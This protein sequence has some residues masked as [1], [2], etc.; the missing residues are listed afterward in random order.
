MEDKIKRYIYYLENDYAFVKEGLIGVNDYFTSNSEKFVKAFLSEYSESNK[1]NLFGNIFFKGRNSLNESNREL[2]KHFLQI[3]F[4]S[5]FYYILANQSTYDKLLNSESTE[6]QILS[7]LSSFIK[8]HIVD[9]SLLSLTFDNE[10][11]DKTLIDTFYQ[12]IDD[13]SDFKIDLYKKVSSLKTSINKEKIH[14]ITK[15]IKLFIKVK[16]DVLDSLIL[17][18]IKFSYLKRYVLNNNEIFCTIADD[19]NSS[20]LVASLDILELD[21]S[22]DLQHSINVTSF[23]NTPDINEL[24]N[25]ELIKENYKK[26]LL[27][28]SE[29]NHILKDRISKSRFLL[30]FRPIL[31]EIDK[32]SI[33]GNSFDLPSIMLLINALR[34]KTNINLNSGIS[35]TG[36]LSF[37]PDGKIYVEKIFGEREKL[38]AIKNYNNTYSERPIKAVYVPTNNLQNFEN[39]LSHFEFK[40][41][42]SFY[43]VKDIDS[44]YLK[45]LDTLDDLEILDPF[46]SYIKEIV[47][48]FSFSNEYISLFDIKES[49]FNLKERSKEIVE[50]SINGV[51]IPSFFNDDPSINANVYNYIYA[52]NRLNFSFD[53]SPLPILINIEEDYIKSNNLIDYLKK[54][55]EKYNISD[56]DISNLANT[57][58]SMVFL[59]YTNKVKKSDQVFF[60]ISTL[61]SLK[62]NNYINF[63]ANCI[64]QSKFV[65]EKLK[66]DLQIK[67]KSLFY[68]FSSFGNK[69]DELF[70]SDNIGL[71]LPFEIYKTKINN[72]NASFNQFIDIFYN[73]KDDNNLP[74]YLPLSITLSKNSNI[75][76][77]IVSKSSLVDYFDEVIEFINNNNQVLHTIVGVAGTGKT[78]LLFSL[79]YFSLMRANDP[80]IPHYINITNKNKNDVDKIFYENISDTNIDDIEE[81]LGYSFSTIFILEAN[82]ISFIN[83]NELKNIILELKSKL[84]KI[85][86]KF[87]RKHKLIVLYRSDT[88]SK[89]NESLY[90]KLKNISLTW[91]LKSVSKK[92]IKDYIKR[93]GG[94]SG[95]SLFQKINYSIPDLIEIPLFINFINWLAVKSKSDFLNNYT[96]DSVS[97][98]YSIFTREYLRNEYKK[99]ESIRLFEWSREDDERNKILSLNEIDFAKYYNDNKIYNLEKKPHAIELILMLIANNLG[100]NFLDTK[101]NEQISFYCNDNK[102]K[103]LKDYVF[104]EK[105]LPNNKKLNFKTLANN[106]ILKYGS[107]FEIEFLHPSF[108]DYYQA[109]S[110]FYNLETGTIVSLEDKEHYTKA[111][112]DCSNYQVIIHFIDIF[113]V[114]YPNIDSW[115]Y[116]N[117]LNLQEESYFLIG[118]SYSGYKEYNSLEAYKKV[119]EINPNNVKT[120]NNIGLVYGHLGEDELSLFHLKKAI[121][122]DNNYEFSFFNLGI[123]YMK[124]GDLEEAI[125][126]FK[127]SI[128]IVPE[129]YFNYYWVAEC[130][131]YLGNELE[132]LRYIKKA[133]ENQ[134]RDI[135]L[136]D[137]DLAIFYQIL[138]NEIE[139][140]KYFEKACNIKNQTKNIIET[141]FKF[142]LNRKNYKG[143]IK[144]FKKMV[145]LYPENSYIFFILSDLISYFK[146]EDL[147]DFI[148]SL[149]ENIEY[150]GYSFSYMVLGLA[151]YYRK[152][153]VNAEKNYLISMSLD[154]NIIQNYINLSMLYESQQEFEKALIYQKKALEI[155][156]TN[157]LVLNNIALLYS[158][159]SQFETAEFYYNKIDILSNDF[160]CISKSKFFELKED[161]DNAI[162]IAKKGLELNKNNI[163]IYFSLGNLYF[164]KENYNLAL[165]YFNKS[166]E[167]LNSDINFD[168]ISIFLSNKPDKD[169]IYYRIFSCKLKLNK[170]DEARN[171]LVYLIEN[172]IVRD[173]WVYY[174]LISTYDNLNDLGNNLKYYIDIKNR[175]NDNASFILSITMSKYF[176]FGLKKALSFY[177][178]VFE[179]NRDYYFAFVKYLSNNNLPNLAIEVLE[180]MINSGKYN[181][182]EILL[183]KIEVYKDANID[184]KNL[185]SEKEIK[186]LLISYPEIKSEFYKG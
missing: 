79:S 106:T 139:A 75:I 164:K 147:N 21:T 93:V 122:I 152:D 132:T 45:S 154:P 172:N 77:D 104:V 34:Y 8:N 116:L 171:I 7:S 108:A 6:E 26:L 63:F 37:V 113:E 59:A 118:K 48:K 28:L 138:G 144:H 78:S 12:T 35:A 90:D 111:L 56:S 117:H 124:I 66:L 166:L 125:K 22:L 140:S 47:Q 119:L 98:I 95:L 94:E 179:E 24:K 57:K 128:D 74:S 146:E 145:Q 181:E 133:Y 178:S 42:I 31:I 87:E 52:Y 40:K 115:Q 46:E 89:D 127:R 114:T 15:N 100:S 49:I 82:N 148:N 91:Q 62:K 102:Y 129:G 170:I 36:S 168:N 158:I 151:Y 1:L 134:N 39:N 41:A 141:M 137:L 72:D 55:F 176:N 167:I 4:I 18:I 16:I 51:S 92:S 157:E 149:E 162:E 169:L 156:D 83:E 20:V 76:K 135:E 17:E 33:K 130:Y 109:K 99:W 105:D 185:F 163:N 101:L 150:T 84:E 173:Y 143:V 186:S 5:K 182:K 53:K 54:Y 85:N 23:I 19:K 107:N 10:L 120:N 13:I 61:N 81:F 177:F 159:L 71:K 70:S 73:N 32:R 112:N 110:I 58:N 68:K 25:E 86:G 103:W 29:E 180:V 153:L 50:S 64:E 161:Y 44:L 43:E 27:S 175:E 38:Q 30:T 11:E 14:N 80:L 183:R 60:D 123:H 97:Q 155:D 184:F 126:Y 9:L 136:L 121:E 67:N 131:S 174:D 69:S 88:S 3:S 142:D 160:F 165:D 65:S 2:L 96:I